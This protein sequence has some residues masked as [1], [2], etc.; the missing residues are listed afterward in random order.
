MVGF[1]SL[2][3]KIFIVS[4]WGCSSQQRFHHYD[5]LTHASMQRNDWRSPFCYSSPK[6]EWVGIYCK[7]T[8]VGLFFNR[9]SFL[10]SFSSNNRTSSVYPASFDT[11]L[12][13]ERVELRG[14]NEQMLWVEPT[15]KLYECFEYYSIIVPSNSACSFLHRPRVIWYTTLCKPPLN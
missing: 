4:H 6:N 3:L 13:K 9:R 1:L 15:Q 5:S 7:P 11:V 2:L 14:S 10:S 12:R 8:T